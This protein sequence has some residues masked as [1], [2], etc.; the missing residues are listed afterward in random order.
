MISG[1][2]VRVCSRF[3]CFMA[4]IRRKAMMFIYK[5]TLK[6]YKVQ[7]ALVVGNEEVTLEILCLWC[8]RIR[9]SSV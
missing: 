8:G 1:N 7:F 4:F 6:N 5:V 9:D 3:L 2:S